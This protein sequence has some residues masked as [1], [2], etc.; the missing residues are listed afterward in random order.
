MKPTTPDMSTAL[1]LSKLAFVAGWQARREDRFPNCETAWEHFLIEVS[2]S[3][4]E[5]NR[6][7]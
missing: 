7:E 2:H 1:A 3:I 4:E 6:N 5:S